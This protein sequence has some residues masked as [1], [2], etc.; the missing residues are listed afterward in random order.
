[1]CEQLLK[2]WQNQVDAA[3]N[4]GCKTRF[5]R[6]GQLSFCREEA[7]AH[8]QAA[9]YA[10]KLVCQHP[11]ALVPQETEPEDLSPTPTGGIEVHTIWRGK[12][13]QQALVGTLS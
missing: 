5:R 11:P 13:F 4:T 9:T 6:A 3:A 1:M 12:A 8:T 10:P 2:P 7:A